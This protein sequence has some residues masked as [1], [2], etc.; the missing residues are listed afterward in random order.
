[1][2]TFSVTGIV[3]RSERNKFD[4]FVVFGCLKTSRG[5]YLAFNMLASIGNF[6]CFCSSYVFFSSLKRSSLRFFSSA[7]VYIS[8]A[9]ENGIFVEEYHAWFDVSETYRL[10]PLGMF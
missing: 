3:C 1:M 9:R 5:I 2:G 4:I 8:L 6:R 7:M 10:E